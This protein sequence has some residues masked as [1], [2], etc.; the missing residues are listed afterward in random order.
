M[1]IKH[2]KFERTGGFAG[3]RFATEFDVSD[4]TQEQADQLQKLV[5]DLEFER[6]PAAL[7]KNPAIPDSFTYSITVNQHTVTAT[8]SSV[9]EKMQPL[10]D[11]L[12]Q[13]TRQRMM[14]K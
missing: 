7:Q 13:I 11:T 1:D 12:M 2:V 8:D 10:L 6:L 3:I 9:P 14:K 4:L 5:N